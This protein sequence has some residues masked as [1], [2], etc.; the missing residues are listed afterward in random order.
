MNTINCDRIFLSLATVDLK[1]VLN[2]NLGHK[3][4]SW[5]CWKEY[6]KR[7]VGGERVFDRVASGI[8]Y[9]L[10]FFANSSLQI[11]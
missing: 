11:L 8:F 1:I 2:S 5:V 4:T 9:P 7:E 3:S 6:L 10:N